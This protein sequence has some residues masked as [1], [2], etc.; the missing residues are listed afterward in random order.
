MIWVAAV[1][2]V[3]T[4][5]A[6]TYNTFI[7]LQQRAHQAWADIDTQLKRRYDLVPAL[8]ETVKG[9]AAHEKTTLDEVVKTRSAAQVL[10]GSEWELG[11]R[12]RRESQ[13]V[14]ALGGLF[15]LAEAYP[16]L[17][18]SQRFATL[19]QDLAEIED[20]IQNA[21]RYYNAVVRDLNTALA[22]FPNLLVARLFA[23]RR[24]QF[25]ELDDPAERRAAAVQLDAD[26]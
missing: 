26:D 6:W 4:W 14:R 5:A 1:V 9:Y 8:V 15:A 10:D 12:A 2:A 20:G 23:F 3:G 17:K 24:R 22:K 16:D 25:F 11:N 21:R 18:A 19:Q 13:L 7:R